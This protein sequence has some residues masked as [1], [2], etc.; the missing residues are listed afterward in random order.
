MKFN[1]GTGITIFFLLFICT[2]AFVLYQSTLQDESLVATNYYEKDLHYQDHYD[3]LTN[4]SLLKTKLIVEHDDK[5]QLI[6]ITFPTDITLTAKGIVT[7]YHPALKSSDMTYDFTLLETNIYTIPTG[8][9]SKG[10]W[11]V[12]IEWTNDSIDYYQEEEII[13][14]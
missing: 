3:K 11:K 1:W 8:K 6:T 9:L 10:R 13:I 2:L 12:Q 4:T 14:P 7:L 5:Y